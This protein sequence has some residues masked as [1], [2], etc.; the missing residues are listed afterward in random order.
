MPFA[1]WSHQGSYT[2]LVRLL[3]AGNGKPSTSKEKTGK[4]LPIWLKLVRQGAVIT[5]YDSA[6]G[7]TWTECGHENLGNVEGAAFVGLAV[8]SHQKDQLATAQFTEVS[9]Q[10][11]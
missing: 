8:C 5:C 10:K 4:K 9:L 1:L 6:D 3:R 11:R 7:Q 2:E